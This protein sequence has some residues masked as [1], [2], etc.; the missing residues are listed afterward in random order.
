MKRQYWES[1]RQKYFGGL[2]DSTS[3]V[4]YREMMA[5]VSLYN[6]GRVASVSLK[7]ELKI[8]CILFFSLQSVC[9][10]AHPTYK[11]PLF[12]LF[13]SKYVFEWTMSLKA[14][15]WRLSIIETQS[16]N[17]GPILHPRSMIRKMESAIVLATKGGSIGC[18]MWLNVIFTC[19]ITDPCSGQLPSPLLFPDCGVPLLET[20]LLHAASTRRPH[21]ALSTLWSRIIRSEDTLL[22]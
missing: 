9:T 5:A 16:L 6:L 22:A 20:S 19:D 14:P 15:L 2:T 8:N 17:E 21:R 4:V 11:R 7:V 12:I 13:L 3:N 18:S 1:T 10:K